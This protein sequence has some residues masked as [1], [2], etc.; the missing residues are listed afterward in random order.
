MPV[1]KQSLWL[2]IKENYQLYLFL[3]VPIF[4]TI[5]FQYVP[6][7]GVV[8]AFK[9]YSI[10]AGIFASPWIGLE[11]FERFLTSYQFL[12]V[13]INTL[14][15]SVYSLL[16]GFPLP[17]L[18]ALL[19]NSIPFK[20]YK[21]IV[22]SVTYMPH[23]ISTVVMVG[24][25]MQIFNARI[26]VFGVFWKAVTGEMAPDIIAEPG[27]FRHLYVWSG[28]WQSTG[29]SSII[30][31][32]ALSSADKELHEAA[33]IDGATLFQRV[34]HIDLPCI[35]PTASILL[36]MSAGGIMSVGFTKVL[37]M[38][39]NLN[40]STSEVISTYVYKIGVVTNGGDFSF[41]SAVGLFNSV[42]NLTLM[43][44]V[45]SICRKLGGS[46]LW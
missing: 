39:N 10:R 30:Y 37:L 19:L 2:Q 32:A 41:G 16:A 20:K 26:G 1:R 27:A 24:L 38:Q 34:L 8:I 31:F 44:L 3:A 33:Q 14:S 6:M 46:S 15:V 12:R 21:K 11:N 45:N 29:W 40:I 5:L 43:I 36:I 42:T 25:I 23:F 22:Q 35:L 4:L 28:I 9:Q 7:A 13:V 18:F 17:I